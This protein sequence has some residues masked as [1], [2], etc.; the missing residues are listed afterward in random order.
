MRPYNNIRLSEFPDV[1]DIHC[2][3][4]KSSVGRLRRGETADYKTLKVVHNDRGYVSSASKKAARRYLKRID[5]QI[6]NK[7]V[8]RDLHEAN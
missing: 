5:R 1:A 4:R 2:E 7:A 8:L 6:A 3:G